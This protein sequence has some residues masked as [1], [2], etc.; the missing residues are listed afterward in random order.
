MNILFLVFHF[1]PISGGGVIVAV[2]LVNTLAK[3]GHKITVITPN[4]EWIGPK[5]E[6]EINSNVKVIYVEVP[7]KTKIK[8]AARL[9]K[10]PLQKK[11]E[12]LGKKEKFDFVFSIFHPFHF[13]P[14]A[15][16]ACANKLNIPS[17]VKIDDAL[18]EKA[19]G[20]KAIQRK[21]EKRI[22]SK[23][24][25]NSSHLL[26]MNE[27]TRKIVNEY[28]NVENKK[29]S[30][31]P[32]GID[33]AFFDIQERGKEKII[34]F[35]GAMYHHRGIDFLLKTVKKVSKEIPDVK[36]VLIGEG[37]EKEKLEEIV[38]KEKISNYVI[39]KGWIDRKQIPKE[40][41]NASI[42]IGPLK[43][44]TV[45]QNALPIKVLEYMVSGLPII[46]LKG[47]LP[48]NVLLD[49]ENG[50][51]VDNVN[52]LSEKLIELLNDF[53]LNTKMGNK[54]IQMAQKFSWENIVNQIIEIQKKL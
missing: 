11:A 19:S 44:T 38:R 6:P 15:A 54:S 39:F 37:P 16:V 30:I 26:V 20:I 52:T 50:F 10:K 9:C 27:E 53:E 40:L 7:S 29:I 25:Q 1:P 33:L 28:Y 49:K 51:F 45:T 36:F 31:I 32:N 4:V 14:R 21:I 35:L 5:Y 48:S 17:I 34:L 2:D 3:L 43:L 23:T 18:F 42:G 8:V 47:T 12:E 41:S 22:N 46:A 24:L 13:A